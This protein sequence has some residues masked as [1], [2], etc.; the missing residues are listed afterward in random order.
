MFDDI[1]PLD[2]VMPG[3]SYLGVSDTN[4]ANRDIANARNA[5]EA[6]E[7]KKARDH[8]TYQQ[9]RSL[10]FQ[11]KQALRQ[12]EFQKRNLNTM[13][14]FQERMSN[15][16]IQRRMSDLKRAGL[17]PILAGK[18]DASSPAGAMAQGAAGSGGIGSS[19][20]A[21]AHGYTA[22]NK[23]QAML[24]NVSAF[25]MARKAKAEANIAE[26]NSQKTGFFG[27][28]WKSMKDD[29]KG[30]KDSA[31]AFQKDAKEGKHMDTINKYLD[32]ADR[33]MIEKLKSLKYD[34][35]TPLSNKKGYGDPGDIGYDIP[36]FDMP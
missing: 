14:G 30:I 1:N 3:I 32:E 17:N 35:G 26:D 28:I 6:V 4:E 25:S 23:I 27:Q 7:A 9:S 5:F 15:T 29:L 20:K 16:A 2:L 24:D 8:S 31:D 33:V 12:M 22:Q 13:Y 21:N 36:M 34:K 11:D 10:T 18:Y 19:A